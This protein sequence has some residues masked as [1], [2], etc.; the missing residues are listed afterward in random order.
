MDLAGQVD[1][2]LKDRDL[3][4]FDREAMRA[5]RRHGLH[6]QVLEPD[7]VATV[8]TPGSA[9]E[10]DQDSHRALQRRRESNRSHA[11]I[12][13]VDPDG[14]IGRKLLG[15]KVLDSQDLVVVERPT[16]KPAVDRRRTF[17]NGERL[18]RHPGA[19]HEPPVLA[20]GEDLGGVDLE[21]VQ[22]LL[23]GRQQD[24]LKWTGHL[25]GH[26]PR[27][28]RLRGSW[29]HGGRGWWF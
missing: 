14:L 28:G 16:E 11:A 19:Q 7:G 13:G 29:L 20:D 15:G 23:R 4:H 26:K 18:R 27:R 3:G 6:R 21:E 22:G 10:Q 5:E 25:L 24:G 8:E 2:F 9:A 1:P 12:A 17:R